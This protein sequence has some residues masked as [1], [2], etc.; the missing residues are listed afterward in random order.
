MV[1]FWAVFH[2]PLGL[3]GLDIVAKVLPQ[4]SL[5]PQTQAVSL[6]FV[7]LLELTGTVWLINSTI[8]PF[9]PVPTSLNFRFNEVWREKG[10]LPASATG[11]LVLLVAVAAMA[12]VTQGVSTTE[13]SNGSSAL[14]S[15]LNSTPLARVAIYMAYCGLTPVLE[16]YVYRGFLLSSLATYMRWPLAILLSAFLFSLS[17]LSPQGFLPLFC[18][19]CCLGTA[20][21][22]NGNLATSFVI[23]SLYNAVVLTKALL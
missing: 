10:W 9:G 6:V 4:Q 18:V 7:Q 21:T 15:L 11:L 3:G 23:H 17:H 14:T 19:G 5:D 22:W 1:I 13:V 20:Y 2:I 8:Q 16:E 12:S